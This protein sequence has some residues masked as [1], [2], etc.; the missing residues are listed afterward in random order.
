MSEPRWADELH[1][2]GEDQPAEPA[3]LFYANVDEFVRSY[4]LPNWRR[5]TLHTSWCAKWWEHAEAITRLEA[6]WESWEKQRL[7]PGTGMATW[8]RDFA[9]H[10]MAV[11]TDRD[12]GP[13]FKCDVTKGRHEVPALW[14]TDLPPEGMF[15]DGN[16]EE[17]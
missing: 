7:E 2:D 3:R 15:R 4:L 11:L 9:D 6:L 12:A 13:F 8:W 10:H 1:S 5:N 16:E 17:S 14:A